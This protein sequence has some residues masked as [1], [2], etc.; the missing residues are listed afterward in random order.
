MLRYLLDACIL[1]EPSRPKPDPATIGRLARHEGTLATASVV[2]HELN[3]GVERLPD[4]ARKRAL[5]LYIREVVEATLPIL[6]YDEKAAAWHAAARA[7]LERRGLTVPFADGQVA[8]I[9]ATNDLVLVTRNIEH[10]QAFDNLLVER[11]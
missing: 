9:A 5:R 11:W 7:D 3:F 6:P 8:A 2:W 10:F 4:S 1:S